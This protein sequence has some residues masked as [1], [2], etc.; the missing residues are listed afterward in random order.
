MFDVATRQFRLD[1]FVGECRAAH[2]AD[3]TMRESRGACSEISDGLVAASKLRTSRE[4]DLYVFGVRV[5]GIV[6][7]RWEWD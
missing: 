2:W 6:G 3:P 5:V 1:W 7:C 4:G